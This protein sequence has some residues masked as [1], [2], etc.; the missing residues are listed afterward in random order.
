M[1]CHA[2]RVYDRLKELY[3][4]GGPDLIEFPDYLGEGF[5]TLQAAQTLAPFLAASRLC[6]RIHSTAEICE[7]L[8][9]YAKPDFP[10]RAVHELERYSLV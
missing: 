6:V 5:V 2:A 7:V 9:G 3:P 1:R 10:S 8:D 4:D